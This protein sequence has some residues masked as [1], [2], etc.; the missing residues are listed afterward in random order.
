MQTE[1]S[2]APRDRQYLELLEEFAQRVAQNYN[3]AGPFP[4]IFNFGKTAEAE[5][6]ELLLRIAVF[7][8]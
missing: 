8:P 7:T 6:R 3:M 4:K 5:L 1:T 2:T